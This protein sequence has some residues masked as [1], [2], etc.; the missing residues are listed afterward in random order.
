MISNV[1]QIK[2]VILCFL[3]CRP[4]YASCSAFGCAAIS[5]RSP[6]FHAFPPHPFY[7][8]LPI[9]PWMNNGNLP[10]T[11]RLSERAITTAKQCFWIRIRIRIHSPPSTSPPSKYQKF[12]KL[13]NSAISPASGT[14]LI[15]GPLYP[16]DTKRFYQHSRP[17]SGCRCSFSPSIALVYWLLCTLQQV[18]SKT[19]RPQIEQ[20]RVA[21]ISGRRG[22]SGQEKVSPT[23]HYLEIREQSPLNWL[24]NSPDRLCWPKAK[25]MKM[26]S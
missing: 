5:G 19:Q 23:C 16:T 20:Q 10:H 7:P 17:T 8:G 22:T 3:L 9:F 2:A 4:C 21:H 13:E 25:A 15:Y 6:F 26:I 24:R 14:L 1:E 12:L 18:K 11:I